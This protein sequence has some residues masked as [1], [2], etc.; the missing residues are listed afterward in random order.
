MRPLET[1][2]LAKGGTAERTVR[3]ADITVPDIRPLALTHPERR[4]AKA[5]GRY[6]RDLCGLLFAARVDAD[7]P[8]A[9]W[10]P[11]LWHAQTG[12][13][14]ADAEPMLEAWHIGHELTEA[15]GYWPW[16]SDQR[17]LDRDGANGR[18]F[19]RDE[20]KA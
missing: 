6:Y 15:L 17:L 3:L 20:E 10:I 1:I 11:D 4:W 19:Y 13:S 5:L 12:L 9:I 2:T 16:F 14:R 7:Y 8:L 18:N